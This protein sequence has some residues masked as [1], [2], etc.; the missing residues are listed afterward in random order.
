M[1][2]VN[3]IVKIFFVLYLYL[4]SFYVFLKSL[5]ARDEVASAAIGVRVRVSNFLQI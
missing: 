3:K 4:H 2:V 1:E 5:S